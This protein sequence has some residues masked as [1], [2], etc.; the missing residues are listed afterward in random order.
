MD[1][2]GGIRYQLLT[3]TATVLSEADRRSSE[4]AVLVVHEFLTDQTENEKHVRNATDWEAFLDLLADSPKPGQLIG[5]INVSGQP[6]L[7]SPAR[8]YLGKA[9]RNLRS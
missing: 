8:L 4:R 3:A 9:T 7:D 5:P 6:L 2:V 1:S